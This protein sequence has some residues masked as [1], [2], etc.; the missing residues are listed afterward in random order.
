MPSMIRLIIDSEGGVWSDF[1]DPRPVMLSDALASAESADVEVE[2]YEAKVWS[3][4]RVSLAPL[5]PASEYTIRATTG[6][7]PNSLITFTFGGDSNALYARQLRASTL[8]AALNSLDDMATAGGCDVRPT[9]GVD[10]D[11]S[12]RVTFRDPGSRAAIA[13]SVENGQTATVTEKAAG[14]VTTREV[15]EIRIRQ[16]VSCVLGNATDS[17]AA[18]IS[19]PDPGL[20]AIKIDE[21][22]TSGSWTLTIGATAT[23]PLDH[24]ATA[25]DV[26]DAV[27]DASAASTWT[28]RGDPRR[29]F[30]IRFNAAS[31][32]TVTLTD[33]LQGWAG[34]SGLVDFRDLV[35]AKRMSGKPLVLSI[36]KSDGAII[37]NGEVITFNG[38]LITYH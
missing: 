4:E 25:Q 9:S 28:V 19:N 10:G 18:T 27:L 38:K 6:F 20:W 30:T 37:Y 5:T 35:S 32:P 26:L 1:R 11:V 15:Q 29:G 23:T 13:V 21:R 16:A 7:D 12:F 8:E 17:V 22:A 31:P 34:R 24:D 14:D 3:R 33:N 36:L 2:I